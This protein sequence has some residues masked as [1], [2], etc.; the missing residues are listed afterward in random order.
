MLFELLR[1]IET[2]GGPVTMADLQRQLGSCSGVSGCPFIARLPKTI[3][4]TR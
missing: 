4:L 3:E 2:A 1:L